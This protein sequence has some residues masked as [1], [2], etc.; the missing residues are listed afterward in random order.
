MLNALPGERDNYGQLEQISTLSEKGY[1]TFPLDGLDG[2][3]ARIYGCKF[4]E[5][6]TS[7]VPDNLYL[8]SVRHVLLNHQ[9]GKVT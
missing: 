1:V 8:P 2:N 7:A 9:G 3:P 4:G 5:M 6:V